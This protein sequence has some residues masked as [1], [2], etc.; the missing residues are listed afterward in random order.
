MGATQ[1]QTC[2]R[3]LNPLTQSALPVAGVVLPDRGR[4][5]CGSRSTPP[6]MKMR[7]CCSSGIHS[8]RIRAAE[9]LAWAMIAAV[10]RSISRLQM[11]LQNVRK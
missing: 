5:A 3:P 4:S 8:C 10:L 11:D 2:Q 7:I 1:G 6:R 9:L